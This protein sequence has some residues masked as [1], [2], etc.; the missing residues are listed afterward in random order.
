[1]ADKVSF[2]AIAW[3]CLARNL[4]I[5]LIPYLFFGWVHPGIQQLQMFPLW[6]AFGV[7]SFFYL[8]LRSSANT[9]ACKPFSPW[10]LFLS[11]MLLG[12]SLV[13]IFWKI[14]GL[15]SSFYIIFI[16][17][18]IRWILYIMETIKLRAE[19]LRRRPMPCLSTQ[20]RRRITF[21]TG[22]LIPLLLVAGSPAVPL[23]SISFVLTA[24]SQ[25][26]A[27]CE[28]LFQ[29]LRQDLPI[30]GNLG[31]EPNSFAG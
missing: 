24:F 12:S 5:G 23:L 9:Q 2:R 4:V 28:I 13:A 18:A 31:N 27:A 19:D 8:I 3:C 20:I 15:P 16:G 7:I 30:P 26:S 29:T 6:C 14:L 22:A 25:W 21:V 10:T 11:C 1:M 17:F